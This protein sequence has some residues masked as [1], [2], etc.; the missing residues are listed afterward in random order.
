MKNSNLFIHIILLALAGALA[1]Y[2]Y[3]QHQ[4]SRLLQTLFKDSQTGGA[5]QI[6]FQISTLIDLEML[7]KNKPEEAS[8]VAREII[9][10]SPSMLNDYLKMPT[11]SNSAKETINQTIQKAKEY[12]GT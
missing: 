10:I 5:L 4:K 6:Q 8:Q 2:S 12:C 7:R 3:Q 1:I 11:I 9:C